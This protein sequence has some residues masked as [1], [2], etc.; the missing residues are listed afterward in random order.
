MIIMEYSNEAVSLVEQVL[1]E[2]RFRDKAINVAKN[3]E[4]DLENAIKTND[5][6]KVK[7]LAELYT[8]ALNFIREAKSQKNVNKY[9]SL[10]NWLIF[11]IV[12]FPLSA[13]VNAIINKDK[14][15]QS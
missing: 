11:L 1:N 12:P 3:S 8:R 15:K 2:G 14:T 7:R 6:K 13:G 4:Y 5:T 10:P 9:W